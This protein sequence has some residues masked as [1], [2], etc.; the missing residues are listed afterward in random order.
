LERTE[1]SILTRLERAELEARERRLAAEAE[2]ERLLETAAR[3]ARE[4]EAGSAAEIR[5]ALAALRTQHVE[6]AN[7]EV[8]RIDA[9]LAEIDRSPGVDAS[10]AAVVD[11]RFETAV[12]LVVEAVL[13]EG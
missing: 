4:I 2:A 7:E 6:H 5:R 8:A 13:M 3:D 1:T 9:K 12:Q 10:A 11:R